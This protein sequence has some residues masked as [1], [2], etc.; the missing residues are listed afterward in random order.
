MT[1]Q[2][3]Q[4]SWSHGTPCALAQVPNGFLRKRAFNTK[5]RPTA[6][7]RIPLLQQ[8]RPHLHPLELRSRGLLP[9]SGKVAPPGPPA[10]GNGGYHSVL[11]PACC[12]LFRQY[13]QRCTL[14]TRTVSWWSALDL[15]KARRTSIARAI[16]GSGVT[17][18]AVGAA[19]HDENFCGSCFCLLLPPWNARRYSN[20]V[21]STL[22]LLPFL[23]AIRLYLRS[24]RLV[25]VPTLRT[26][27]G[28]FPISCLLHFRLSK[29]AYFGAISIEHEGD[30][31]P[32][33]TSM[34]RLGR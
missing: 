7:T 15:L 29:G 30:T 26:A 18:A 16:R 23:R 5:P 34:S 17:D 24:A 21:L 3:I 20:G 2:F 22:R 12:P 6:S 11:P 10:R 9:I 14:S 4:S 19:E 28:L 31:P 33:V 8:L 27:G 1:A 25:W 13:D 32:T